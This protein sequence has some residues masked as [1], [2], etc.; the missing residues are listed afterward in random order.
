MARVLSN[1]AL[2]Y[3]PL[4]LLVVLTLGFGLI[5]ERLFL[6]ANLV[7]VL[8][9]AAP[10]ALL[11][12]A[13]FV[14]LITAGVDLSAGVAVALCAILMAS[15]LDAGAGLPL[16]LAVGLASM[17]ALGL[18]NGFV[19]AVLRIPP[20]VATLA[21]MVA[22]Q[23]ATLTFAQKGVL[24]INEPVLKSLGVARTLG[25]P[26]S[27][28][29]TAMVAVATAFLMRRTRFGLHSYAIGSDNGGAELAGVR[30]RR[31]TILVYM[32]SGVFAFF[33]AVL[34]VSRVPIVTPN[35]GGT[36]L[37]LDAISAAVIGGTSVLGGRGT[38]MGV[39]AGAVIVS[40]LTNVLRIF[41]VD[42]SSIDLFKG[43]IIMGALI[44]DRA[45]SAVAVS[46]AEFK[47]R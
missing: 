11:A 18:F 8:G 34:T 21:T 43:L 37:L 36:S 30:I 44:G 47:F 45:I 29:A 22:V 13:A 2:A 35:I 33:T 19:I 41:G 4:V 6:A 20:F 38:V 28:F 9:Q 23:G 24:I 3:I 12:L 17:L 26:N 27:I 32:A 25:I 14:V 46:S 5:D 42:P 10:I 40:L 7:N 16:A 31:Q 39:L 1:G 15:Q